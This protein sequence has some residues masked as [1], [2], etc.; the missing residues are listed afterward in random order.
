ML[1]NIISVKNYHEYHLVTVSPW[2]LLMGLEVLFMIVGVVGWF[3]FRG[4]GLV[5][6][7]IVGVVIISWA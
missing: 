6:L 2:P 5:L 3:L 1:L 7:G 4:V